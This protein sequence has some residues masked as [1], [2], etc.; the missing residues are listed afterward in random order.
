MALTR[1]TFD[2]TLSTKI[3]ITDPVVM[4]NKGGNTARDLGFLID[5]S[6]LAQSN[7]AIIFKHSD[8]TLHFVTTDGGGDTNGSFTINTKVDISTGNISAG[9]LNLTGNITTGSGTT[10]F[11]GNLIPSANITYDLGSATNRWRDIF[12]SGNTINLGGASIKT[13]A[14]SGAIAL[15]PP[16]TA[17]NPNPT[18][19]VI[20]PVGSITTVATT[21]GEISG[22]NL[23]NAANTAATNQTTTLSNLIVDGNL[24][25]NKYIVGNLI[26]NVNVSYSLGNSTNRFKDLW[27]ANSSIYLGNIV[28]SAT[29]TALKINNVEVQS[30]YTLSSI[31]AANIS[32]QVAN[33]LVAGTVYTN[34]QPN[35]TSLGTLASLSVTGNISAG[36]IS[37]TGISGTLSTASQTNITAVGTLDSLSVTGNISAGNISATGISGTLSTAAQTNITSVGTLGSLAVTGNI[38]AGNISAT[39]I[40]GTLS[41]A[42]Q[43]NI[44]AVGTLDS[45]I[46]TGNITSSTGNFIGNG[47]LLT[48]LPASYANTNVA[49]YLPT[50]TGNISAGNISVTTNVSVTGNISASYLLGNGSQLTGLSS[51]YSNTNVA[52]YL[53]TYSGNLGG[54]LTTAS[55]PY[56]TGLGTLGSLAVTGNISAGNISATGI[57]GT[58]STA[59]QNNITSV[60]TLGSLSVTGNISAANLTTTANVF[61]S[62]LYTTDGIRWSGNGNLFSSGTSLTFTSSTAPPASGNVKGDK[63]YN[64]SDDTLYEYINDGTTSYWVD[65]QSGLI[66]GNASGTIGP[67]TVDGNLTVLGN[68]ISVNTVGDIVS[69]TG[70]VTLTS[71]AFGKIHVCTGTTADYTII[72]PA[73][74][75]NTGKIITFQMSNALTKLV[76]LDGNASETIDGSLTRIMWANEAA[77]LYCNGTSWTKIAGKSVPMNVLLYKTGGNQ[78]VGSG[79]ATKLTLETLGANTAPAAM[80]DTSLSRI[81]IVR[82]GLYNIT[83]SGRITNISTSTNSE[84]L[85][86]KNGSEYAITSRYMTTGDWGS[87]QFSMLVSAVVNDY[88]ETYVRQYSGGNQNF[89]SGDFMNSIY[90]YETSVW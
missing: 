58:L 2:Q 44:T 59:A 84:T 57:S 61:A 72:L 68:L 80:Y 36:N 20:S 4:I 75:G 8:Q 90:A 26:P 79:V 30:L 82:P 87:C 71:T 32:G 28:L 3:E 37:A 24:T 23:A 88:F 69:V 49:S 12:L 19:V 29:D 66:N 78:S 85:G 65:I 13:D 62:T 5:R 56:I 60:G 55:Q 15:I 63:W 52:S 77:T 35:I 18:G 50:Y 17:S 64:T 6:Y 73:A 76:T 67:T 40:S 31:N 48:G 86:Y 53:P 14:S 33:A 51:S 16:S 47:A 25:F 89:L 42:S 39:G 45:L 70:N 43:T 9:N 83:H 74:S 10:Q 41:T 38:S 54:T 34:A 7:V 27:V 11:T 22:N 46:V 1:P 21:G 81:K